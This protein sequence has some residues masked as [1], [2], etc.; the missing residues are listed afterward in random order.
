MSNLLFLLQQMLF[1]SMPLL[2]V[3]IGGLFSEKSGVVNIAL[4]GL[5]IFGAFTG[6]LFLYLTDGM[7]NGQVALI[8]AMVVA[9]AGGI[10][11]SLLHAYASV[12]MKANQAIS[13]AALNIL[14]PALAVFIAKELT[15]SELI[16]FKNRFY[17][18]SVP[19]LSKIPILGPILF[20]RAYI[21]TYAAILIFIV[22][23]FVIT[24]TRFGLRL[25]ASGESPQA[26]DVAGVNVSRVRYISIILSGAF[27]G[28]GG[29]IFFIPTSVE[30]S[31]NVSG[32]GFLAIA[33][34]V[35]SKWD[36]KRIIFTS[37]FFG[38]MQTIA[39]AYSGL[40]FLSNIHFIPSEFYKMIPYIATLIILTLANSEST[41][42]DALGEPYDVS[43]R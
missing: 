9:M 40:G 16:P 29:V 31:A 20:E 23:L 39:S 33:V 4:E 28:L 6:I 13:G 27:A 42:P 1:F 35:F 37:L 21:T 32:Y 26:L 41:A 3:A 8:L 30:F 12:S 14:A 7:I 17:I 36:I 34:L 43:K 10:G 15:P 11:L 38:I 18:E 25:R 5:M 22:S 24:K 19:I 2:V